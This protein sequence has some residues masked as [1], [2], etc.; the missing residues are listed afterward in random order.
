MS[1]RKTNRLYISDLSSEKKH[2]S[3]QRLNEKDNLVEVPEGA[4]KTSRRLGRGPGS[5][6]GTTAG[7]GQKGQ[8]A[9]A[10][11][12]RRGFEGGQM[13]LALRIPKRGFR[14]IFSTYFQP[15]NLSIL[16]KKGLS[17]QITPEILQAKGII[18]SSEGKIKILGTGEITKSLHIIADAVSKSAI[19]KIEKLGGKV[20]IRKQNKVTE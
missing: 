17:G 7:R 20:E 18:K 4:I 12:M 6:N 16:E 8:R 15:V 13:R 3:K 9:R 19:E 10:S 2:K 5:G 1:K 14:N 11:S